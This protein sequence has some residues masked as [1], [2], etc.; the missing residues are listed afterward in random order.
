MQEHRGGIEGCYTR[1]T[2]DVSGKN[3]KKATP[4]GLFQLAIAIGPTGEVLETNVITETNTLKNKE[5]ENCVSAI[6]K[7][8]HFGKLGAYDRY[9]VTYPFQFN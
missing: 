1:A 5:I 4:R 6:V 9:N 2:P 8:M 7:K 3:A